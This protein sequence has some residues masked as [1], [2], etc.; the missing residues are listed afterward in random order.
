MIDMPRHGIE[1]SDADYWVHLHVWTHDLFCYQ[2]EVMLDFLRLNPHLAIESNGKSKDGTITGKGYLIPKNAFFI[3]RRDCPPQAFPR[4]DWNM[5]SDRKLS[6]WG[7]LIVR[8][9]ITKGFLHFPSL[10]VRAERTRDGQFAGYDAVCT[11]HG[12]FKYEV[13]T[14][15]TDTPNIFVQTAELNHRPTLAPSDNGWIDEDFQLP[16]FTG[17]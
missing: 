2:R 1:T 8:S 7:E 15:R 4:I 6:A 3:E 16:P 5:L 10:L 12:Q 17:V 13:K 14:D 11:W 9:L